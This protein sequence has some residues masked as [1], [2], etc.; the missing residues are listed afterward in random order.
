MFCSFFYIFSKI[1]KAFIVN[2]ID[3]G[4]IEMEV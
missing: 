1:V 4:Q 3:K 2:Y